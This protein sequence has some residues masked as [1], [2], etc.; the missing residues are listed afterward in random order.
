MKQL[1]LVAT[2]FLPITALTGFFGQNFGWLVRH[3]RSL[4]AFMVFGV[5]GVVLS[6]G[7]PLRL[8][9]PQPL[10]RLS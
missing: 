1:T 6:C 3:V 9:P 7:D 4:W 5:G 10:P 2:M 8:V